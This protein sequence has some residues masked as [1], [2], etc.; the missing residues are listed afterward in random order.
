MEQQRVKA[1][2]AVLVTVTGTDEAG[3][4][5]TL[6]TRGILRDME[7]GWSLQYEEVSPDNLEAS[8][9]YVELSGQSVTVVRTGNV[10][11][12]IV[13]DENE[14]FIGSYQTPLGEFTLRVFSTDVTVK[15]RGAIG[16]IHL[17]YQVSLSSML[18]RVGEMA[19]RTLDIRF[20]PCRS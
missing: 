3:E 16:H 18:S 19:M 4:T 6:S 17:V 10:V 15:R 1:E 13:Y 11:S 9:T 7:D 2:R 14:T 5:M 12:T 8:Q 20:T